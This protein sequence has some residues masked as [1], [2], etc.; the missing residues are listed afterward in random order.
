[1]C[2]LPLQD[3]WQEEA[4]KRPAFED[5]VTSLRAMLHTATAQR[6]QS[7]TCVGRQH[8]DRCSLT[9]AIALKCTTAAY[10]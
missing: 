8:F 1:M 3:C 4:I 10:H 6:Q 9:Y 7:L 5:V 2:A